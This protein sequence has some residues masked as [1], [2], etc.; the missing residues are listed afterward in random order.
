MVKKQLIMDTAL[1][2]FAENGIESTSIKQ[3]TDRCGI[4]KGAFYLSFTSKDELVFAIIEHFISEF[5]AEIDR[6]V[7]QTQQTDQLLYSFFYSSFS[8]FQEKSHYAKIF[9]KE[10]I[11]ALNQDIFLAM[12]KYDEFVNAVVFSIID[13]QFP[14]LKENMR[15]DLAY[16]IKGFSKFYP[17]LSVLSNYP[18]D[19]EQLCRSLAEKT[20][21][22]AR[23]ASIPFI[24]EEYFSTSKLCYLSPS[25]EQL[26]DLLLKTKN[27]IS[28]VIIRQSIELLCDN[29]EEM[30]LPPAVVQG[31]LK[32]L[33]MNS[34]CKWAAY[35]YELY[36]KQ[37]KKAE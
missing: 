32:N 19:L 2:L 13:M 9:M 23:H 31:L 18:I 29:L 27:D 17:E 11:T 21:I 4:S 12:N 10:N 7:R 37:Q 25:K 22:L 3:I 8:Q 15:A 34:H 16:T 26:N 24:T 30:T 28:D 33:Q 36:S 20:A 14:Q 5:V 35:Q 1:E 6:A